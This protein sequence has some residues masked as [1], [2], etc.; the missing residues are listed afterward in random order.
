MCRWLAYSGSPLLLERMLLEPEHSLIDQ[1]LNARLGAHATN[2]DGFGVGWYGEGQMPALYRT[3]RPAWNDPNLA[4]LSRQIRSEMVF[5]HVRA[6]TGTAVQQTNCHPFRYGK[7]LWM[8]NGAISDF[9]KV[10]RELVLAVAPDLYPEI[11]GSTDSE[12]FFYLALTFG[13]ER[14]P[15]AAVARAVG[16]IE[17]VGQGHAIAHPLQ[18]TVAV[19]DGRALW[20]FRYA[21]SGRSR[22]LFYSSDPATLRW[23]YPQNPIF[24]EIDDRT[25]LV[26]SEPLGSTRGVWNEL[27]NAHSC[28]VRNGGIEISAF[29]PAASI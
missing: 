27:P 2:G 13:L 20:A 22:T 23:R 17:Q 26:V 3:T 25:K 28:T 16:F 1:S 8:H 15:P 18:M 5:A 19:G 11:E 9:Q 12:L 14:N 21:S 6:S 7:W 29:K 24:R 4:E 10:K